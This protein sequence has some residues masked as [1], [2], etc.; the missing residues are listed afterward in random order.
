[1]Y[2]SAAPD[3][4]P[5][6]PAGD[7]TVPGIT[8][9]RFVYLIGRLRNRQITMEEATELFQLQQQMIAAAVASRTSASPPPSASGN[10]PSVAPTPTPGSPPAFDDD[11]LALSLLAMGAGAGVLAAILRRAQEGPRKPAA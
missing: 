2:G 3:L 5:P 9:P 6:P 7:A 1:M 10:R 11:S 8:N 4:P